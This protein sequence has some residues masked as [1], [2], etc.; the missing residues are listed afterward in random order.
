MK[1]PFSDVDTSIPSLKAPPPGPR[2][3]EVLESQIDDQNELMNTLITE[4]RRNTEAV[5]ELDDMMRYSSRWSRLL[6]LLLIVLTVVLTALTVVLVLQ[7]AG[8]V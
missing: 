1:N 6:T 2:E 3:T 7:N 5:N 8:M 4:L